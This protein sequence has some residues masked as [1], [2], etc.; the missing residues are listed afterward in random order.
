MTV[1]YC[2]PWVLPGATSIAIEDGA[3]VVEDELIAA[4]GERSL[5]CKQF[6]PAR[7][8]NLD[9][10]AILPG[11][12]NTHSHLELTAMRGFLDKEDNDFVAWLKK[13]TY[14]RLEWMTPE[15]LYVSAAWGAAEAARAGITCV[16]DASC[17]AYESMSAIRD[18]GLRG[19]VFQESFGPD[20]RL[21][22]EN[23]ASLKNQ[24]SR[25]RSVESSRVRAGVSPHAPYTVSAPQ[26]KLICELAL[27]EG[28]PLM[29]HAAESSAEHLL[30]HQGEGPF[31][32]GLITRGIEWKAPGVSSIQYLKANGV[33][34][35]QPLLAH[36]IRVDEADIKCLAE[37]KARVA[38]CP[39]SNAK[40]GHGRAPVARMLA[41]GLIVGLGTDSVASNNTSDLLDEARFAMLMARADCDPGTLPFFDANIGFQMAT[42]GGAL[43]LGLEGQTGEL[44]TGLQAD[45]AVV[46]IAGI[47]QLPSYDP[48]STLFFASSGRD[49]ILTVVAGREIFC[50]GCVTTVDEN[51][52]RER[53]KLIEKK[54]SL[55]I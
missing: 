44:K 36:C 46:S 34:E 8:E 1:I 26:L 33:L 18:V 53:M 48:I 2:A 52:L 23:L 22:R 29:M 4:V 43:A 17:A 3:V 49:V 12:V 35:T 37:T 32:V 30:M 42:A 28:L 38:H 25:L 54:L 14:A 51:E 5:L 27:A 47:H 7:I 10:A 50:K 24:I 19:T 31:A 16:G 20:P 11:L 55:A 6:Q 41:N 40:L 21:A 39:K 9:E 45:F 15:D 13:L